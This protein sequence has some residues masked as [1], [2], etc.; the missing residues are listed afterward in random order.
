M[1]LAT[2]CSVLVCGGVALQEDT[3][4]QRSKVNQ[5]WQEQKARKEVSSPHG[6][7]RRVAPNLTILALALLEEGGDVGRLSRVASGSVTPSP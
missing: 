7:G 4:G 6:G 3:Q 5:C 1:T 2:F